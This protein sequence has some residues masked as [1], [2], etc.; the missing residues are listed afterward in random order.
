MSELRGA[1]R[2]RIRTSRNAYRKSVESTLNSNISV[3]NPPDSSIPLPPWKV[4]KKAP[5]PPKPWPVEDV[6]ALTAADAKHLEH[7][8][9]FAYR[10][11]FGDGFE[12]GRRA[13]ETELDRHWVMVSRNVRAHA[14]RPSYSERRRRELEWVKPSPGDFTGR[15]TAEE[16]FGVERA[17]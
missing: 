7:E 9:R 5:Q 11:G 17:A 14:G 16:Y 1:S 13:A 8:R 4:P 15:L 2:S 6:I 12:A 10:C 3:A